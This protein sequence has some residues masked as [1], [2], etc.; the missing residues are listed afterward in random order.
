MRA[1]AWNLV[2]GLSLTGLA[3]TTPTQGVARPVS[4]RRNVQTAVEDSVF[5]AV[6]LPPPMVGQLVDNDIFDAAGAVRPGADTTLSFALP[7]TGAMTA[8][9]LGERVQWSFRAPDGSTTIPGTTANTDDYVS[10]EPGDLPGFW[11]R[12]PAS[13]VWRVEVEATRKDSTATFMIF[14]RADE[15]L[16]RNAHLETMVR[17]ALPLESNVA[18]PGDVVF[19]R[20]FITDKSKPLAGIQWNVRATTPDTSVV[21][22]PVYDDGRHS[23]GHRGDG[24]Y[25]GAF[26][27]GHKEG[28]YLI[29]AV[30]QG[31]DSVT[32]FVHD[33]VAVRDDSHPNGR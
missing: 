16:P 32:F 20:T 30:G 31:P 14:V 23:D 12:R 27:V 3:C 15:D 24:M 5:A 26:R 17:S 10:N 11:L 19:V 2:V 9:L 33:V 28:S 25:V 6:R 21:T 4:A 18:R 1:S 8:V 22:V 13:G 29:R 7:V